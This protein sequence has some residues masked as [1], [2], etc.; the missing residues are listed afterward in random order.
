MKTYII[1]YVLLLLIPTTLAQGRGNGNRKAN[2]SK[3]SKGIGNQKNQNNKD[4]NSAPVAESSSPSKI[5]SGSQFCSQ[6]FPQ[7]AIADGSQNKA[8][9]CSSTVQ[10]AIPSINNMVSTLIVEPKSGAKIDAKSTITVKILIS[11]LITGFFSNAQTEYYTL[12]QQLDS[13]GIIQGHQHITV[14][15]LGDS[16]RP[17]DA[18]KFDFFKGLNEKGDGS[19]S[20]DI[21]AGT[22]SSGKSYRICSITGSFSHQPV[23]MPVAQRGSQDDCIRV[24]T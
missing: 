19:L 14:Q 17:L 12:P 1:F 2:R 13:N 10:G 22:L 16:T 3:K 6:S 4:E 15:D 11:N 20:V 23:I 21:P 8:G 7:L 9:D 24:D 18:S 5:E